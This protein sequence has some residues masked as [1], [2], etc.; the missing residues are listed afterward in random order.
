MSF[1]KTVFCVAILVGCLTANATANTI[2]VDA[3]TDPPDGSSPAA[4]T[5]RRAV[6]AANTNLAVGGCSAGGSSGYDVIQLAPGHYDLRPGADEDANATG[7]LDVIGKLI[8][9]GTKGAAL[10]SIYSD[11]DRV[12]DV[13]SGSASLIVMGL[14]LRGG[15][16]SGLIGANG[17]VVRQIRGEMQIY[18]STITEGV[19]ARGG[20]I[21][22]YGGSTMQLFRS[23]VFG[24][25]AT[26]LGG[27]I[28]N[29]STSATTLTNVTMSGN[30]AHDGGGLL[31]YGHIT[32]ASSTI[33][34][35]RAY[36]GGGMMVELSA[37]LAGPTVTLTNTIIAQNG[38]NFSD[39]LYCYGSV[40]GGGYNLIQ[41]TSCD[42]DQP[43]NTQFGVDP[44]LS[45]LFDFGKGIPTHALLD[46]SP[47]LHAGAPASSGV[48]C[49]GNDARNVTRPTN[50]CDIGA[51]QRSF[52]FT[53]NTT[54]D[55]V[56]DDPGDG[57]C[58]T[59]TNQCS[60]RAAIQESVA[61][62]DLHTV[63]LPAGSYNV[64]L[65]G[66]DDAGGDIDVRPLTT[67]SQR[68][69]AVFGAGVGLTR[70]VGTGADRLLDIHG[71]IGFKTP[72]TAVA[73]IGVT[74][75]GGHVHA[76]SSEP[77]G[78]GIFVSDAAFLLLDS[79][80]SGNQVDGGSGG[81]IAADDA[82]ATFFLRDSNVVLERVAVLD[83]R[84]VSNEGSVS[85]GG[86]VYIGNGALRV[87]NS[88][89]SHNEADYG[90]GLADVH[91]TGPSGI[92]YSTVVDN[93]STNGG[94][95]YYSGYTSFPVPTLKS[96]LIARNKS[97]TMQAGDGPDCIT[98]SGSAWLSLGYNLIGD[99]TGC[100][101]SG[102]TS[103]NKLDVDPRLSTLQRTFALPAYLPFA[104]SPALNQVG[105]DCSDAV[106][107]PVM[108]DQGYD[109]RTRW[110]GAGAIEGG[111][112]LF[113]DGFD[114][115]I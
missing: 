11:G 31:T 29:N 69:I 94:G 13:A 2:V 60:L 18:D 55:F 44:H 93:V 73:L 8:I 50:A 114:P 68:Q 101:L 21:Y 24:N 75:T 51:Y 6:Q 5:L 52:T 41:H 104:S 54:A 83:N 40:H 37:P 16:V 87:T 71:D 80:L 46:G 22:H 77:H 61:S 34:F 19:A 110:C 53:V 100:A 108:V 98:T 23:T 26:D 112:L 78:G 28:Y 99:S 35:N 14:T 47:A 33:A 91:N 32:V 30:V 72:P 113:M 4:C 56:D 95:I 25:V 96:V 43:N 88:T 9:I 82:S 62:E 84:A 86:G 58:R 92:A 67:D 45:P 59:A 48:A 97:L 15:N 27:G 7:D 36:S 39:D 20:G 115:D 3:S 106:L 70:I 81:G 66:S 90:G 111:D 64:N 65:V 102:D 76:G 12:L 109:Q 79:V 107:R 57:L 49:P 74:V 10:T 1:H 85:Y 38:T 63:R 103:S 42:L 105:D 17:G 89:I